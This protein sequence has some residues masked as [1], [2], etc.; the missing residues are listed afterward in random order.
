VVVLA[1]GQ[2][3]EHVP[4]CPPSAPRCP[5]PA[6]FAEAG[7]IRIQAPGLSVEQGEGIEPGQLT[8]IGYS[9]SRYPATAAL[10]RRDR[11]YKARSH[12][13]SPEKQPAPGRAPGAALSDAPPDLHLQAP[14]PKRKPRTATAA[15]ATADLACIPMHM[16]CTRSRANHSP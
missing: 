12:R 14:M 15:R 16:P 10:I 13:R 7:Q 6:G 4:Y 8:V 2:V 11:Q 1:R 5:F 3:P 9:A